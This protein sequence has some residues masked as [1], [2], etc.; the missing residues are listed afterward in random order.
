MSR[1]IVKNL[2]KTFT[3]EKLKEHFSQKGHVTDASISKTAQGKSRRFGFVGFRT[4]K[5]AEEAIKYF[6][7]TYIFTSKIAVESAKSSGDKSISRAWSKYTA[8]SSAYK[9]IH[10]DEEEQRKLEEEK[11][12]E[13]IRIENSK[14]NKNTEFSNEFSLH[15][16]LKSLD[17]NDDSKLNEYMSVMRAKKGAS[18][19]LWSNDD[20]SLNDLSK[21][22]QIPKKSKDDDL[23]EDIPVISKQT[24]DKHTTDNK[25]M[26]V[27][28]A[29]SKDTNLIAKINENTIPSEVSSKENTEPE[30]E[31]KKDQKEISI[32][33]IADSGRLFVKNIPY[34]CTT[35]ELEKHFE[36]YG[37]LTEVHIPITLDSKKPKGF[38][39]IQFMFPE[40]AVNAYLQ[41]DG[42]IFQGRLLNVLPGMDKV[43]T[44]EFEINP[45][46]YKSKKEKERRKN[47][48]KEF[49]WNT[50][51]MNSDAITAA[52][53]R[54]LNVTKADILNPEDDGLATRLALAET[55]I[56][57]ET[58]EY[59]TTSGVDLDSFSKNKER[60]KTIIL[61]KNIPFDTEEN[62]L[63]DLFGNFGTLNRIVLPPTKT[64][65]LVEFIEPNEAKSAF[66]R[67]AYKKLHHIPMF[68]EWAPIGSLKP[69]D[70]NNNIKKSEETTDEAVDLN[71]KEVKRDMLNK[72]IEEAKDEEGSATLFVKNLS[73]STSTDKLKETFA[74]VKGFLSAKVSTKLH[75]KS[76]AKLSMGF[77]FLN[78]DTKENAKDCMKIK[79]YTKLDGHALQ[80]KLSIANTNKNDKN[81]LKA[82]VK[83]G[84]T[85]LIIR[86]IP[87]E[88][89]K[90]DVQQLFRSF[91]QVKSLRLPKKFDGS[92]RGFGFVD[93]LTKQE[94][95]NAF[96]TLGSTH[97]YGRHLVLE[98]ADDKKSVDNNISDDPFN[99]SDSVEEPNKKKIK[100]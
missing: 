14:I 25:E 17:S 61:V 58:K 8:G 70:G 34:T 6:N 27:T 3:P 71:D 89:T 40:R 47:A 28:V 69:V 66:M 31:I 4:E 53:A 10:E 75:P 50:L 55:H 82:D 37:P 94:A 96:E 68:L 41:L 11:K 91:G 63:E 48:T 12:N 19:H 72:P 88:A 100:V 78:F 95:K 81:K 45:D 38:A 29:E 52:I 97:L 15:N 43:K 21:T 86:N 54:K 9:K 56:I 67:L 49:S 84:G 7:N 30:G 87:F 16:K 74:G 80:L 2:P 26:T 57:T 64:I 36:E 23:Y 33:I 60:S 65:A 24:N 98:W 76:G 92:H 62:E 93:F 79:Q 59:L 73:F 42:S 85:K 99:T 5:E 35:A 20:N 22:Q 90:R 32:D 83:I 18:D 44:E 39:F 51:F 13:E 1:L 46:N 77:G